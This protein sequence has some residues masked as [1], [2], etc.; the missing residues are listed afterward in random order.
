MTRT[1]LGIFPHPDDEAYAAGGTLALA[2]ERGASVYVVTATRG[3][4]G[5]HYHRD[6]AERRTLA[7]IRGDELACACGRLGAAPP[8]LLDL[9]DGG[10][11]DVDFPSVVARLVAV[12]RELR[13]EVVVSLGPD[14]V[15]GHPDHIALYRLVVAAVRSAAG[16]DR[17]PI[18]PLGPAHAVSRLLLCAF[19]PE[20]FRPQYER[21]LGTDLAGAMRLVDPRRLGASEAEVAV[22][23]PI[24]AVAERKLA[25]IAC[26]RSQL[27]GDDP[28]TL[29][30]AGIIDRLLATETFTVDGP[31]PGGAP[32]GDPFAGLPL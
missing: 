30:P 6:P 20:L 29:F 11:S 14:G 28:R 8:R 18:E 22:A 3:E 17:F 12:I 1:L 2:A 23:V 4:R 21:M 10:L 16:G 25:A 5:K 19:P 31:L 32:L 27:P 24:H 9:S 7:E 13:P 15:Y 26:H